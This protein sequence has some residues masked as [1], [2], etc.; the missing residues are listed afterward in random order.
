MKSG[1]VE[2]QE[3]EANEV[4][5]RG[6]TAKQVGKAAKRNK[7]K[8]REKKTNTIIHLG[9]PFPRPEPSDTSRNERMLRNNDESMMCRHLT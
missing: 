7:T 9:F 1:E 6:R 2:R 4:I 8:R 3:A 5:Q